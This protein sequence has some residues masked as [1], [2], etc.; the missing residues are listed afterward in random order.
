MEVAGNL[1]VA[2]RCCRPHTYVLWPTHVRP[3]A[4]ARTSYGRCTYVLS[5]THLHAFSDANKNM[6]ARELPPVLSSFCLFRNFFLHFSREIFGGMEKS[7]YLCTRKTEEAPSRERLAAASESFLRPPRGGD[8][9]AQLFCARGV[10]SLT[11]W[12]KDECST[13]KQKVQDKTNRH[14]EK[15]GILSLRGNETAPFPLRGRGGKE[16]LY[17]EEF[18][19][20]SG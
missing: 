7:A 6:Y 12:Q 18:D 19:P 16:L 14:S 20:G 9:A 17:N 11:D 13:G 3:M 15:R 4:N 8:P 1:F 5:S 2:R 10:R